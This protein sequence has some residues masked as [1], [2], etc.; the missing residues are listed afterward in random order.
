MSNKAPKPPEPPYEPCGTCTGGWV[1]VTSS[2][3][4]Y[5]MAERCWC[6]KAHQ[7]KLKQ[8]GVGSSP[9]VIA[10]GQE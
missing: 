3:G 4:D 5:I 10:G 8:L 1:Y 7:D 6:W 2:N 9:L